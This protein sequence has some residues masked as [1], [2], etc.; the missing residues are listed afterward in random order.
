MWSYEDAWLVPDYDSTERLTA[1]M[2]YEE[3]DEYTYLSVTEEMI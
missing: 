3:D 2:G 1:M